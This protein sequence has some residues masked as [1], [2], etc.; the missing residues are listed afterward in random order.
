[1]NL[2]IIPDVEDQLACFAQA[3]QQERDRAEEEAL[4]AAGEA[5][6]NTLLEQRGYHLPTSAPAASKAAA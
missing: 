5:L 2:T 4:Q 3:A 1:M 6:L